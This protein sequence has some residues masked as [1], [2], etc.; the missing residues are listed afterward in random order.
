MEK[1]FVANKAFLI[2]PQGK[3]LLIRYAGEGDHANSAGRL[4]IPG[5]RMEAH[6]HP[7]EG[8]AREVKEEVGI[9]ID[10][11]LARPFYIDLWGVRGDVEHEPIVG[12]F[13]AVPVRDEA[14]TLSDEHK[15]SVW[16]DPR[17]PLPEG[18]TDAVRGAIEAYRNNE[19]IVTAADDA[20]KGR[21]GFGLIQV[22]TGN[23]KGKTTAALG[24]AMRAHAIG[25]RVVIIYFDKG[26]T[27]HYS[28]RKILEK[29]GIPFVA[30]G[31]DRIDPVTGRFDFSILEEDK[32]EAARG[33]AEAEKALA[34][35]I[36]L[37]VLDEINS[38]VSLG[39]LDESSVLHLLKKKPER[40]ELVLTGR[41][42]P[43]SFIQKAHLVSEM[44]LR[45]HYFYSGVPAREGLDF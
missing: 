12:V 35:G 14:I 34:Q 26:G 39:M 5:G 43:D 1:K 18:L 24:E 11:A 22:F 29:L 33:L 37:I 2:N 44:R 30:T 38:T 15:E 40:T 16:Y 19:G 7:R 20:I 36:D 41:N 21:E 10:P 25:K 8:L 4:D 28:E 13:Y 31:R 42:V 3:I 6:E 32:Q 23:G 17:G 9:S 45:K 27:T